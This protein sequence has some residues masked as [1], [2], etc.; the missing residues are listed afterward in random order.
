MVY[1]KNRATLLAVKQHKI[2]FVKK[3][4]IMRRKKKKK[5]LHNYSEKTIQKFCIT[6]HLCFTIPEK[7]HMIVPD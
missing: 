2:Y 6:S 7:G 1:H 3:K 4:K 5:L